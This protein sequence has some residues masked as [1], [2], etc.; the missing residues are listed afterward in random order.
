MI[1]DALDKEIKQASKRLFLVIVVAAC[2]VAS[3]VFALR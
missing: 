1:N 2:V 3:V